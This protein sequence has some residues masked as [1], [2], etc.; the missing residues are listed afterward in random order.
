[1]NYVIASISFHKHK[2]AHILAMI[3]KASA[4]HP[5]M[6]RSAIVR[7]MVIDGANTKIYQEMLDELEDWI[8]E[9]RG[10][11][12]YPYNWREQYIKLI[13]KSQGQT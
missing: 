5:N 7:S 3:D 6:T 11:E 2:H 12:N 9:L 13:R 1:M 10:D 4:D 8:N